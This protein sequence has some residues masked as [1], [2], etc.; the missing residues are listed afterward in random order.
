MEAT[1]VDS[2][3]SGALAAILTIKRQGSWVQFPE[4]CVPVDLFAS[5]IK[6]KFI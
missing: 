2:A 3:A 1:L 4:Y 6:H 5:E